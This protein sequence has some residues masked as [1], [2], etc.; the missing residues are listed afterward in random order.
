[1]KI[2]ALDFLNLYSRKT[3]GLK[4][5]VHADLSVN[6]FMTAS[7]SVHIESATFRGPS[8][9]SSKLNKISFATSVHV[10]FRI[11]HPFTPY[12]THSLLSF[13]N[14]FAQGRYKQL[15]ARYKNIIW[16]PCHSI[17]HHTAPP[18]LTNDPPVI[19]SHE[20]N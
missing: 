19:V 18:A 13:H 11:L 4:Y 12:V 1:M 10:L 2:N 6:L 9:F 16:A 3:C 15:R 17:S 5:A 14:T 8:P 20:N 7:L